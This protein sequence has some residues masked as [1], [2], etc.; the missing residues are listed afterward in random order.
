VGKLGYYTPWSMG[1]A[2]LIS[3]SAGL[4]TTLRPNTSNAKWIGYQILA[5]LGRGAGLQIPIVAVQNVLPP[6]QIPIGMALITFT[7]TFGGGLSLA[8]AQTIF[9]HGIVTGLEKFAPTVNIQTV[10][11]AGATAVRNVV[12]SDQI[13]GVL[14]AY[15]LGVDNCFYLSV[16]CSAVIF[17]ASF[18]MGFGTVKKEEK[19]AATKV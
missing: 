6:S 7:Q 12:S 9:S 8:I 11:T 4:M 5:G 18:G 16:A 10:I 13:E 15:N 3:I 2:V 19:S 14:E 17:I 1:S